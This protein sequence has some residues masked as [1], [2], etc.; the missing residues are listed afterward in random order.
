M[1]LNCLSTDELNTKI[2]QIH[3]LS[4][5]AMLEKVVLIVAAYFCIA[6]EIKFIIKENEEAS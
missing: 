3:E 1:H 4:K 6:T 2:D 5:D